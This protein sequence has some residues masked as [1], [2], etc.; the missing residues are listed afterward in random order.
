MTHTRSKSNGQKP[1]ERRGIESPNRDRRPKRVRPRSRLHP[2]K[3]Q[4][5]ISDPTTPTC[6]SSS[7]RG[8][9]GHPISCP[10]RAFTGEHRP[11]AW[12]DYPCGTVR[13]MVN[14]LGGTR[15]E[16][17]IPTAAQ[18]RGRTVA[19]HTTVTT[20]PAEPQYGQPEP[21]ISPR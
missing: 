8:R 21:H 11:G 20:S 19:P 13:R 18:G 1:V 4:P 16:R 7:D 5:S 17:R 6:P 2:T 10:R 14:R 3:S 9:A 12:P 15:R